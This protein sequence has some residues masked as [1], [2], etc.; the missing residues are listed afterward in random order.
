MQGV[1]LSRVSYPAY[2]RL[3]PHDRG[4]DMRPADG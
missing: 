4:G 1:P 2:N 3:E